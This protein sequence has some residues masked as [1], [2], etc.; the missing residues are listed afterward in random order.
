MRAYIQIKSQVLECRIL[1]DIKVSLCQPQ[2]NIWMKNYSQTF[3]CCA[4]NFSGAGN[5][6]DLLKNKNK[7]YMLISE[8]MHNREKREAESPYV[9][10]LWSEPGGNEPTNGT[11]ERAAE[12]KLN[13]NPRHQHT[14]GK[15]LN[16]ESVT[17]RWSVASS[18]EVSI[19]DKFK[20]H[21]TVYEMECSI[22]LRNAKNESYG[23][24]TGN[25]PWLTLTHDNG[26]VN[27]PSRGVS[28]YKKGPFLWL[29]RS[30]VKH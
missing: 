4:T 11:D 22:I 27:E 8:S 3:S 10:K 23:K 1:P 5:F 13:S 16:R 29:P 28:P 30:S 20:S 12:G 24:S 21:F 15:G 2:I 18:V 19:P 9:S 17:K 14:R 26:Q 7:S 25:A 6:P